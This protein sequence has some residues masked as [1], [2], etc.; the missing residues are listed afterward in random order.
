[1]GLAV[2][3][4]RNNLSFMTGF[5]QSRKHRLSALTV[6]LWSDSHTVHLNAIRRFLT[7]KGRKILL[8]QIR[9]KLFGILLIAEAAKLYDKHACLRRRRGCFLRFGLR[10]RGVSWRR[11]GFGLD[12]MLGFLLNGTLMWFGGRFGR[13]ATTVRGHRVRPVTIENDGFPVL[14]RLTG[15]RNVFADNFIAAWRAVEKYGYDENSD[16]HE[17]DGANDSFFQSSI[18]HDLRREYSEKKV[19]GLFSNGK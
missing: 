16:Q 9:G 10:R 15:Q 3:R 12:L 7:Q 8:A 11:N 2:L 19:S 6:F 13:R 14:L 18:H 1:M 4:M 5:L 17:G